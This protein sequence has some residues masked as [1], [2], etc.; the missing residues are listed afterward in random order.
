MLCRWIISGCILCMY[1]MSLRVACFEFCP[2]LSK[3]RLMTPC[4]ASSHSV[5]NVAFPTMVEN[6]LT[7]A[8]RNLSMWT[9][10]GGNVDLQ[11]F[12]LLTSHINTI[13]KFIVSVLLIV[14]D[15]SIW[16]FNFSKVPILLKGLTFLV[17]KVDP[18]QGIGQ[19]FFCEVPICAILVT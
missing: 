13:L 17:K 1:W 6:Y 10:V 5:C 4:L 15:F 11:Y 18:F 12:F 14:C 16:L 7:Y 19:P 2:W 3:N 9:P 8:F